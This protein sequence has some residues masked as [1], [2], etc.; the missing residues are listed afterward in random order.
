[1]V[2]GTEP[3]VDTCIAPSGWLALLWLMV[4]TFVPAL[5]YHCWSPPLG[6]LLGILE[7]K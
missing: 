2:A 5:C 4:F 1:M 6:R 3:R 7:A